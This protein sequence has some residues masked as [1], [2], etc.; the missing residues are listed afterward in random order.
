MPRHLS[1]TRSTIAIDGPIG[2]EHR[3]VGAFSLYAGGSQSDPLRFC[4]CHV[5]QQE[6]RSQ[7][8]SSLCQRR[9][10]IWMS[11]NILFCA[12]RYALVDVRMRLKEQC[13]LRIRFF[14]HT[15]RV[16]VGV[17]IAM[18]DFHLRYIKI[19]RLFCPPGG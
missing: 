6:A 10:T 9:Q 7:V 16:S 4:D 5:A 12:P 2:D 15:P 17:G 14:F 3:D 1:R 18:C 8:S 19:Y 13:C 11:T